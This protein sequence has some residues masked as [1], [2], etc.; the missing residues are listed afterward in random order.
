MKKCEL[1]NSIARVY[2][3][4]DQASLCWDCD[5]RVHAANFL[6]AKHSRNLLCNSCQSLTPWTGSGSKLGPTVSVCQTCFHRNNDRADH[7]DTDEEEEEDDD[8]SSDED[9]GDNQVVPLSFSTTDQPRPPPLAS[10]SSSSSEESTSRFYRRRVV[11]ASNSTIGFSPNRTDENVR[12][13]FRGI[14]R[15]EEKVK[16]SSW[17]WR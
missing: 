4:S 12:S 11:G 5:A 6:V 8:G 17:T 7:N 15:P 3:E 9:D 2:C 13:H 16:M 14:S 10:S 1:C